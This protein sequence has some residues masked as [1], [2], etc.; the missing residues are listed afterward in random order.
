MFFMSTMSVY[1][2]VGSKIIT[3]KSKPISPITMVNLNY[4]VKKNY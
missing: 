4:S 3:E 1:G 2:Q